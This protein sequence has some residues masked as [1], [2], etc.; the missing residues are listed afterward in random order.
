MA[1]SKKSDLS[2]KQ[3]DHN[4]RGELS[5][6]EAKGNA[7]QPDPTSAKSETYGANKKDVGRRFPPSV[8]S[9]IESSDEDSCPDPQ[10]PTSKDHRDHGS[11]NGTDIGALFNEMRQF[12]QEVRGRL[13][14]MNASIQVVIKFLSSTH[15]RGSKAVES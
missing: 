4:L 15:N 1:Q 8:D 7:S 11:T 10:P 12:R 2:S 5:L 3:S 14:E 13:D 6:E 9:S